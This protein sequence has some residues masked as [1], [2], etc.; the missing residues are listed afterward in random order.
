M[1]RK[2][3]PS[4]IATCSRCGLRRQ[5]NAGRKRKAKETGLCRDCFLSLEWNCPAC[6]RTMPLTTRGVHLHHSHQMSIASLESN[7]IEAED[8]RADL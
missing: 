5:V 4:E 1:S 2:L 7:S 8:S 6:G 3:G